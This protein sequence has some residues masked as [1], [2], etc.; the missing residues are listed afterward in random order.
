MDK[1]SSPNTAQ[2]IEHL[3]FSNRQG[4]FV[5][6]NV[7]SP[8]FD[9][10]KLVGT[11]YNDLASLYKGVGIQNNFDPKELVGSE[12]IL[13]VSETETTLSDD[14]G[15]HYTLSEIE[16]ANVETFISNYKF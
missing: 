12:L 14:W 1:D 16:Y 4:V 11:L 7:N 2:N 10:N 9:K 8:T 3:F 5:M 15:M 6:I 13:N